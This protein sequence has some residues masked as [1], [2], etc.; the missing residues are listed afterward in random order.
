MNLRGFYLR[1]A[2]QLDPERRNAALQR[3]AQTLLA[4]PL[5]GVTDIIP[6]YTNLYLEYDMNIL[7]EV[8]LRRWAAQAESSEQ[9]LEARTLSVPVRYDGVDLGSVATQTGLTVEEVI[10][11][12]S[13]VA[14]HVYAVGFTP[15]F[16]FM[17]EVDETLRLS[18]REP[19][20]A[21]PAHSVALAG[22]QT[23][24]YPLASPGGWHLLATS[25]EDGR[26]TARARSSILQAVYG[27]LQA[28]ARLRYKK[29]MTALRKGDPSG[30]PPGHVGYCMLTFVIRNGLSELRNGRQAYAAYVRRLT[31]AW[32]VRERP[33]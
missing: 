22:R 11:R 2:E 19:R 1:F 20:A 29:K 13:Q 6:G 4:R 12:H 3:L 27:P 31:K 18:R 23:G 32:K 24:I 15:G 26:L 16:P 8:H 21:V 28:S 33:C 7:S 17:A 14:Y 30:H 9:T 10:A 5:A 25:W